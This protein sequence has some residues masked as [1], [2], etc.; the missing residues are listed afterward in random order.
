MYS[1]CFQKRLDEYPNTLSVRSAVLSVTSSDG[2]FCRLS[3]DPKPKVV[4]I[5]WVVEC[6]EQRQ[7]VDELKF[8][9]EL[10]GMNVAGVNKVCILHES[11]SGRSS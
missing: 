9:V 7:K 10:E 2:K 8:K 1:Y 3:N 4:G 5:A 11:R 6:V